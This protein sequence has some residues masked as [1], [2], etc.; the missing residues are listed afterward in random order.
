M[1]FPANLNVVAA[2]SIAGIGPDRTRVILVA[3]PAATRNVHE[4]AARGSFG[5][6]HIRLEN[7]PTPGNPK[8]SL[9]APLSVLALLR[10]LSEPVQVGA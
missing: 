3:D 5:D 4:V 6:L 10:R 9:L 1:G 2:L 8:T 7:L